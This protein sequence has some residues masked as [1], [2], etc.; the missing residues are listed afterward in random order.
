[1]ELLRPSR[2]RT[3]L[4]E[5]AYAALNI[6]LAVA[7]LVAVITVGSPYLAI[8][9][10][11]LSKWRVFAVRPQY[12]YAHLIAN[13]VDIIVGLSFVSL[14]YLATG[15]I[16]VQI[17]LTLLYSVWL[18]VLKPR[19]KRKYVVAQAAVALFFGITA[20][21]QISYDW[22]SS[23]VVIAV[24]VIG[25]TSARHAL[26]AYEE[27]HS[28]IFSL[29]WAFVVA[30]I[31]WLAYHWTFGYQFGNSGVIQIPQV[32]IIITALAFLAERTY[33]SYRKNEHE[34]QMSDILMPLLLVVS[35]ISVLLL[36]F[37]GIETI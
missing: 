13:M 4:S 25:Y 8:L 36:A 26:T 6:G 32:A 35:I 15:S 1:M 7:I 3:L 33:A 29:I 20:L 31:G 14:V 19:S 27:P 34:I 17:V 18:L 9:I 2:R 37:N 22:W 24:W 5:V 12:W 23:M 21:M 30:E 28:H 11:V 10:F 16:V